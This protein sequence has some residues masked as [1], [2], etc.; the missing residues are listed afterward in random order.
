MQKYLFVIIY[1]II[2]T[3][4]ASP[5]KDILI[6]GNEITKEE[7]ILDTI[8]QSIGDTINP[9][10]T[11]QDFVNLNA[12]GLFEMLQYGIHTKILYIP[13]Y[14]LKNHIQE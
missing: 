8:Q 14:Y 12:T 6:I 7:F 5:I 11:N 1:L 3:I 9:T 2:S 10:L 13:L 4:F